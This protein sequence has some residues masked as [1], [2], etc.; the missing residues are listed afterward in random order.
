MH[1][2][3]V[4]R[5]DD[6][7]RARANLTNHVW[8]RHDFTWDQARS[9]FSG[10]PGDGLNIGYE[11]VD[12]HARSSRRDRVALRFTGSRAG[13]LK[14]TY[15][16]LARATSQ[17]ANLL[18]RCGV[19]RGERVFVLLDAV[20]QA[21]VAGL[22]VLRFG[23]V[24]TTLPMTGSQGTVSG[25]VHPHEAVVG[26]LAS[27]VYALDLHDD[28]TV[29]MSVPAG[30]LTHTAYSVIAT[31]TAG[32]TSLIDTRSGSPKVPADPGVI[33][34][35]P[36]PASPTAGISPATSPSRI[37]AATSDTPG[38]PRSPEGRRP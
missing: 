22:A 3:A 4:I 5:K 29:Q 13:P 18:E 31:L 30:R 33:P 34:G 1:N 15:T 28:D 8:T 10:R 6:E 11:T 20:P 17:F 27:A 32:A 37:R 24:L 26:H 36:R 16:E 7:T 23:A 21:Y 38:E 12:R 25:V 35:A 14:V 19:R 9:W 2:G